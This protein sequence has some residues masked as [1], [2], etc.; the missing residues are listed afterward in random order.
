MTLG[1][2]EEFLKQNSLVFLGFELHDAILNAYRQ[3]FP[4]DGPATNLGNWDLFES[5][6]PGMF[7]GMYVFWI[8]KSR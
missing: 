6:N 1:G 5:E 7:A 4:D 8:Q 3:R 2:I